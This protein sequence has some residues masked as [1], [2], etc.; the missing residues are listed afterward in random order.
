M[1]LVAAVPIRAALTG[2]AIQKACSR[3]TQ[4]PAVAAVEARPVQE[5]APTPAVREREVPT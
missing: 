3:A 4:K 5:V 1:F 2:E